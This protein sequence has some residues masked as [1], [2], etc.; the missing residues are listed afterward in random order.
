MKFLRLVSLLLV[1]SFTWTFSSQ[2][3]HAFTRGGYVASASTAFPGQSGNPV[4]FAATPLSAPSSFTNVSGQTWPG[5]YPG[6]LT[7]WPGGTTISSGTNATSGAG[8]SGNPYVF[9]FYKFDAGSGGVTISVSNAIFVGDSFQSNSV[10]NFNIKVTGANVSFIYSSITPRSAL[11]VSPPN[12]AWPSAGAGQQI[13]AASASY[14]DTG[15]FSVPTSDGYQYGIQLDTITGTANIDH[16][17]IWGFGNA[18][19]FLGTSFQVNI[20]NNWMHDGANCNTIP[21]G[22][23]TNYHTDGPGYLN[24]GTPPSNILIQGNTI[25]SIGNTNAI[26]FQAA[27]SAYSNISVVG[28]YLTGFGN[29]VDIG[30]NVTGNNNLTFTDN[31]FG[32]DLPWATNSGSS[33]TG[34]TPL[35]LN[36]STQFTGTTNVWRRNILSVAAGT[37]QLAGTSFVWT[38]ANNGN[39]LWPD[40]TLS[41]S[42]W[43]H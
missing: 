39:Y 33:V 35:H 25:A 16:S 41:T 23:S 30:N 38:S 2:P 10:N 37:S 29:T 11:W 12:G 22:G 3:A 7:T 9:A 34:G 5:A 14:T 8:T 6:S 36:F 13:S 42:D 40:S 4:G 43:S 31:V 19:T 24:S 21:P 27:T 20:T 1:L 17:D 26:A 18:I 32:T 28:N 15:G